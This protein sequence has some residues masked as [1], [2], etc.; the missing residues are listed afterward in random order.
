M[1]K[2][3]TDGLPHDLYRDCMRLD[4]PT[5]Y[6]Q[7]KQSTIQHQGEYIHFKNRR[8]QVKGTPPRL[9]NPFTPKQQGYTPRRDPNAMDVDQGR[10]RLAGAKD[11]LYNKK[12]QEDQRQRQKDE[13][14]RLGTDTTPPRPPFGPREGYF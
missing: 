7:W 10:V 8:E 6:N 14:K 5:M 9:Y 4:R 2:E 3:F 1:S 12:Y 13:D 11:I